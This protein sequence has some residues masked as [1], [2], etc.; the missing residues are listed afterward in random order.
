MPFSQY[1]SL[2]GLHLITEDYYNLYQLLKHKHLR[3]LK[4]CTA[5]KHTVITVEKTIFQTRLHYSPYFW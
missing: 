1:F 3:Q 2:K 5:K 4:I